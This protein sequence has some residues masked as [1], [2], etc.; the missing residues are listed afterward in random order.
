MWITA[1]LVDYRWHNF[2]L[3]YRVPL[4]CWALSPF[5]CSF[6]FC[7]IILSMTFNVDT[8]VV[9]QIKAGS[10][11]RMDFVILNRVFPVFF[12]LLCCFTTWMRTLSD[13]FKTWLVI[14]NHSAYRKWNTQLATGALSGRQTRSVL[15]NS[16]LCMQIQTRSKAWVGWTNFP[17]L[18][19]ALLNSR[20]ICQ[21]LCVCASSPS[22]KGPFIPFWALGNLVEQP[23]RDK[24]GNE[25]TTR[26]TKLTQ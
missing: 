12:T 10:V 25:T 5:N 23:K 7:S 21:S 8:V 1:S 16:H 22:K 6:C 4:I 13:S 14:Y 2:P 11:S 24:W 26:F 19:R 3:W 18:Y 15:L 9:K 17:T 20:F